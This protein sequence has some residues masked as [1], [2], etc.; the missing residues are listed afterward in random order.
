M[1]TILPIAKT[2]FLVGEE[3]ENWSEKGSK[4]NDNDVLQCISD[5][6]CKLLMVAEEN[7]KAIEMINQ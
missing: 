3:L 1:S 2:V 6:V 5:N 4:I 7:K